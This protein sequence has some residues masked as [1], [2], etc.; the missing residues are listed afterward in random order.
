MA[1]GQNVLRSHAANLKNLCP[2]LPRASKLVHMLCPT[3]A[4]TSD[5][6]A[7]FSTFCSGTDSGCSDA[8]QIFKH[9]PLCNRL[10]RFINLELVEASPCSLAIV[11]HEFPVVLASKSK[12]FIRAAILF[13]WLLSKHQCIESVT[14][15]CNTFEQYPQL[16]SDA[17]R[18]STSL[19]TVRLATNNE[20]LCTKSDLVA[21][22]CETSQ[23]E[24]LECDV[25]LVDNSRK[26]EASFANFVRNSISLSKLALAHS[27]L[28]GSAKMVIQS[29][30]DNLSIA[31]LDITTAYLQPDS[32]STFSKFL[33]NNSVLRELTVSGRP[34]EESHD[35]RILCKGLARNRTL[36]KLVLKQ[37][38]FN[39]ADAT[40]FS[41]LLAVNTALQEIDLLTC[42][43]TFLSH[44]CNDEQPASETANSTE[45]KKW[46]QWW[47]VEPFA[48]ALRKSS[49]IR[50]LQLGQNHFNDDELSRLF[51]AAKENHSLRE[52]CFCHIEMDLCS[53]LRCCFDA[54]IM[55]KITVFN[56][57]S[58]PICFAQTLKLFKYL[59][60]IRQHWF[61]TCSSVHLR[62]VCETLISYDTIT[63]VGFDLDLTKQED[64]DIECTKALAGYLATTDS[65]KDLKLSIK[66][67][68]ACTRGIIEGLSR[69]K[70]LEQL[71]MESWSPHNNDM[72]IFCKW[73]QQSR[74]LHGL[75]C[76]FIFTETAGLFL[77]ELAKRLH[78]N[79]TLT[80]L[81][82]DQFDE[83]Q[84]RWQAIK[85]LL[86]RNTSLINR[87]AHFVL[88]ST[89]KRC[90]VAFELVSWHPLVLTRVRELAP[91]SGE[92]ARLKLEK[93]K[94]RLLTDFWQLAGI[95]KEHLCCHES[96]DGSIQIDELGID[97]W[98]AIRKFLSVGDVLDSEPETQRKA[99]KRTVCE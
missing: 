88:G 34:S 73:L 60:P 14:I 49:S 67:Q 99:R 90:A 61:H 85:S 68:N 57:L 25:K 6:S 66:G 5:C 51:T 11:C 72:S 1:P 17:M 7:V 19:K 62:D 94:R 69:N 79:Y 15:E 37:Y 97:A 45:A 63:A 77:L 93:S 55:D 24:E 23:L 26:L 89:M 4:S 92:L 38:T 10:L 56:S 44:V 76:T 47:R 40:T 30:E 41:D 96:A 70:S 12:N 75:F 83:D 28:F 29:L 64:I 78:E 91:V 54:G 59:L 81:D 42:K 80:V 13:H 84:D 87:A 22:I 8:C 39:L 35:M 82:G 65:L 71:A 86:R 36:R 58:K 2:Q 74:T 50:R 43:W 52:L 33:A 48:R 46:G 95:V 9:L 21:A 53:F 31:K 18:R 20:D 32:G 16:F 27:D 3:I 98:M